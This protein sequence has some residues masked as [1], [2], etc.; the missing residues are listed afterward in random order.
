VEKN[1]ANSWAMV[2]MYDKD[3]IKIT[4][5]RIVREPVKDYKRFVF[6]EDGISPRAFV[7]TP[8][9]VMWY[10]GDEHDEHGHIT[11]DPE[12]RY[13]M[14]MKRLKKLETADREIPE[15]ERAIL[16]GDENADITIVSWGS[17][18]GAI[19]DA[20]EIL[21][22]RGY[23]IRFLQIKVFSPFPKNIVRR[24]LSSSNIVIDIEN[25]YLGQAAKVI[26]ME[27]GI[28]I[29]H[30]ALK[31]TGRPVTETEVIK[32]VEKVVKDNVEVIYLK[33]GK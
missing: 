7:G 1:L 23:R 16:Y 21:R 33:D 18:K 17:T 3:K 4:R 20:M 2:R 11:E 14:Y 15:E 32:S 22:D 10:T 29:K 27:T 30:K 25:N 9:I 13:M 28:L 12:T 24:I 26:A 5:G 8:G 19:L 31:W 6:T